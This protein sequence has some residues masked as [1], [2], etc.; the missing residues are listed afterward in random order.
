MNIRWPHF[1]GW[2][3]TITLGIT[4]T[5]SYGVML[6][7]YTVFAVPMSRDL[8]WSLTTLNGG[9]SLMLL[10]AGLLALPVGAWVDRH[11]SR[12]LM[13]LGSVLAVVAVLAWSKVAD[14][15][16]YYLVAFLIGVASAATFYEPAF[17]TVTQWFRR[18]RPKALLVVTIIAGFAST[19]FL[20]LSGWLD[21]RYG[22]RQALVILAILLGVTTIPLHAIVLRRRPEDLGLLPD[23]DTIPS[24]ASTIS[25]DLDGSTLD[26]A[27]RD[28][29]FW[30]LG[31]AFWFA[32][33]V[34][35]GLGVH[36]LALLTAR[37]ESPQLAATIVGLIGAAQVLARIGVTLLGQRI[38]LIG[39]TAVAFVCQAVAAA[40]LLIHGNWLPIIAA[41]L[42]LGA[43]RGAI[44]LLRADLV[45]DRY[46]RAHFGAIN[47]AFA[48]MIVTSAAAAPIG[49]GVLADTW[50]ND[51]AVATMVV[52]ALASSGLLWLAARDPV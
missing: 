19:I 18:D 24:D 52:V 31:G 11:G 44:T 27:L 30:W 35:I 43:G 5:I 6:Y 16:T 20:P 4:T 45:A 36:A 1:Y 49:I 40:L 17:T 33:L 46:G 34:S 41:I 22:W 2:T 9:Y 48:L 29:G 38:S 42:L 51:L 39:A 21:G 32:N 15:R 28:A 3:I 13:T 26:H 8:G 10:V 7:A 47:G 12:L 14:I 25:P 50:G 23:G 37:G